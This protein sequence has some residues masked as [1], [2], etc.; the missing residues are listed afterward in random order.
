MPFVG[1]ILLL[2]VVFAVA[3]A[4]AVF[5][6]TKYAAY[7]IF[8]TG[9]LPAFFVYLYNER[10]K[11]A[12]KTSLTRFKLTMYFISYP[13]LLFPFTYPFRL[14]AH[15]LYSGSSIF[16]NVFLGVVFTALIVLGAFN[17]IQGTILLYGIATF[18]CFAW[19]YWSHRSIDYILFFCEC[20]IFWVV[21]VPL[22]YTQNHYIWI[23]WVSSWY[24]VL[25]LVSKR[26]AEKKNKKGEQTEDDEIEILFCAE[27]W[28]SFIDW[29]FQIIAA[30]FV[31][32]AIFY[33]F[34]VEQQIP[35][36]LF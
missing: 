16:Y 31:W 2:K 27:F 28:E 7:I 36:S 5:T 25:H 22:F 26:N 24:G 6:K 35:F 11:I 20:F 4:I 34:S 12:S 21:Q 8:I 23:L 17:Q 10:E 18:L 29:Y 1:F 14:L 3:Q 32:I 19:R 15:S 13:L 33:G 30:F 9:S